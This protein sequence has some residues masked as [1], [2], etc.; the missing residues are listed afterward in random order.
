[1]RPFSILRRGL[2]RGCPRAPRR[3]F[4]FLLGAGFD[5]AKTLDQQRAN[6]GLDLVDALA[7]RNDDAGNARVADA[8]RRF[9]LHGEPRDFQVNAPLTQLARSA[10]ERLRRC[11]PAAN[12]NRQKESSYPAKRRSMSI[13]LRTNV[14]KIKMAEGTR[15]TCNRHAV[16]PSPH[17]RRHGGLKLIAVV[18]GYAR[19]ARR[20]TGPFP[21]QEPRRI[22]GQVRYLRLITRILDQEMPVIS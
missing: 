22:A 19:P 15:S 14:D 9:Q 7:R 6:L 20:G 11:R 18:I 8:F 3:G 21:D 2:F 12:Q 4:G 1:M 16:L 17:L 10:R 5:K 13:R